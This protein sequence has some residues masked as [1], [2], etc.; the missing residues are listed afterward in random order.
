M[1]VKPAVAPPTSDAAVKEKTGKTWPEWFAVL[2]ADGA[3]KL[4]HKQIVA[5][6]SEKYSVAPWWRQQVTVGYERARGLRDKHETTSGFQVGASRTIR[7]P[8]AQVFKAWK[9]AR[10]RNRWLNEPGL[11]V[12]KAT[13]DKSL[14]ITWAD[15]STSV[16]V[17]LYPKGEAKTQV[18]IQHS[19]LP[20]ATAVKRQKAFWAEALDRLK[21]QLEG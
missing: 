20:N 21:A 6:L 17:E 15:G 12:R 19:K 5:I 11:V 10:A 2:D 8:V 4:N 16:D 14:R 7:A 13:T 3:Q 18:T 1:P 9:E